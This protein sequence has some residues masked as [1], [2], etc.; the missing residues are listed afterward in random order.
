MKWL[1]IIAVYLLIGVIQC[2]VFGQK[3]DNKY[4]FWVNITPYLILPLVWPVILIH[5]AFLRVKYL[6]KK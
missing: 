2:L 1:I 5:W 6:I 3:W 4:T